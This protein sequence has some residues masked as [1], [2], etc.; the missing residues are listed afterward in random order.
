[1]FGLIYTELSLSLFLSASVRRFCSRGEASLSRAFP[2]LR[3]SA[4][5]STP[6]FQLRYLFG[7]GGR[8][9][10]VSSSAFHFLFA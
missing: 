10:L 3:L 9:F 8:Y 1:M 4:V 2:H 6:P 5:Q 7:T